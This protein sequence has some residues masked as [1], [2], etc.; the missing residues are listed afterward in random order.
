MSEKPTKPLYG[1]FEVVVDALVEEKPA[2]E[3]GRRPGLRG[4]KKRPAE[5]PEDTARD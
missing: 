2:P 4:R 5:P 3:R 1:K